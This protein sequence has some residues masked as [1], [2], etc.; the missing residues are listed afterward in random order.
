MRAA[1]LTFI[2]VVRFTD[3]MRNRNSH[4][5][6]LLTIAQ[7][8]FLFLFS[9]LSL[10]SCFKENVTSFVPMQCRSLENN[11]GTGCLLHVSNSKRDFEELQR[12]EKEKSQILR[13]I[14]SPPLGRLVILLFCILNRRVLVKLKSLLFL[15]EGEPTAPSALEFYVFSF[16]TGDSSIAISFRFA[17][18]FSIFM[19]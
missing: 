7:M 17:L 6:F 2:N 5:G 4:I 11:R 1:A 13:S 12:E 9:A 8:I 10:C 14:D 18:S 3:L 19:E 15:R 16:K